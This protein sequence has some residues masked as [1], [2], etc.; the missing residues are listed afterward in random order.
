MIPFFSDHESGL[1][2]FDALLFP[3]P[4]AEEVKKLLPIPASVGFCFHDPL[5]LQFG[6]PCSTDI[7][8]VSRE[9]EHPF[10]LNDILVVPL[11]SARQERLDV[12]VYDIDPLLLEKMAKDW[13]ISLQKAI[14]H[15][16]FLTR[17]RYVEPR[18]GLYNQRA[19]QCCEAQLEQWKSFFFLSVVSRRRTVAGGYQATAQL[20]SLLGSVI[21]EPLFY[22]GQGV[23]GFLS[24]QSDHKKACRFSRRL[25]TRLKREKLNRIH[26]GF[27][28]IDDKMSYQNVV[29]G[30]WNALVAAEQRGPYSLCDADSLD[31]RNTHPFALPEK[32]VLRQIQRKW[33]GVDRFGLALF[34]V[35]DETKSTLAL[36]SMLTSAESCFP[37]SSSGQ[38]VLFIDYSPSITRARV[39]DLAAAIE[40]NSGMPPDV[41]Y[42]H[43]PTGTDQSKVDCLRSCRK[44]IVHGSFYGPGSIVSFDHTSL[45]VSG[46][47]YFDE[48]NYK[49]AMKEYRLGLQRQ[50]DDKDLL[51][52]LGVALAEVNRHRE[53]IGCF[54]SV[55]NSW[56][57]NHMALV[58]KGMSC[59]ILGR[60]SEAIQC[61]EK[62]LLAPDHQKQASIEVYL[63][64]GRMYCQNEQY[65][66]AVSL[67]TQWR[68]NREEPDEFMF[69][70]LMGEAC[71]GA[72]QNKEAIGFLQKSLQLYP[73]NADS[74]SM[75]GLL[76]I[77]EGEG[78]DVGLSLCQRAVLMD[79]AEPAHL[80]RMAMARYALEQYDQALLLVR[81]VVQRQKNNDR[82]VLL[83]GQIYEKMG[84]VRKACQSYQRVLVLPGASQ[85]R[86]ITAQKRIKKSRKKV[87]FKKGTI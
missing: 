13:L 4:L 81:Q 56:P 57:D 54:S 26:I 74:L 49:K 87:N 66:K 12:V 18:T 8:A 33:C 80:Y 19:L 45:H 58:N 70:R 46:D 55:L 62:A 78:E 77:L 37:L 31:K 68:H 44:A 22:F 84:Q 28:V 15:Q 17:Q 51:N 50:P 73:R 38:F 24:R 85:E 79:E 65:D 86:I 32:T 9:D 82:A 72:G 6:H 20:G 1:R 75:L 83:R 47:L 61:F 2:P 53:A 71:L 48:G 23:F 76:Y 36:E 69:F 52:S 25:I 10:L 35:A 7:L 41:G 43:W 16:L 39:K 40:K 14:V 60:N 30:C 5:F 42:C 29:T 3:V 11:V 63:Q 59:R 34:S 64:L 67:L 21:G 27:S